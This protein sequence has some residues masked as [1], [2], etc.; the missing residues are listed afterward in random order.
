MFGICVFVLL[1]CII[2]CLLFCGF[3]VSLFFY[4]GHMSSYVSVYIR[5]VFFCCTY[6]RL[7]CVLCNCMRTNKLLFILST[8][9]HI[10][11]PTTVHMCMLCA[12]VCCVHVHVV[13][14]YICCVHAYVVHICMVCE[15][16]YVTM[17]LSAFH[18]H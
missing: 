5:V 6:S 9:L 12:C 7:L 16:V 2:L 17:T 10:C 3:C 18:L 8:Y 14:M 1:I 11:V 4:V 15:C 13:H